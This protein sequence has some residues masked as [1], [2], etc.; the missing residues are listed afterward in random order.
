M[1]MDKKT[2]RLIPIYVSVFMILFFVF[3]YTIRESIYGSNTVAFI[4]IAISILIL[5]IN[6]LRNFNINKCNGI[7]LACSILF[8]LMMLYNN[9]YLRIGN[10]FVPLTYGMFILLP[11]LIA[12]NKKIIEVIKKVIHIFFIEH[13][14]FTL[15]ALIFKKAYVKYLLPFIA[16]GNIILANSQYKIGYNPGLTTHYTTNAIYLS[17]SLLFYVSRF[18][19]NRKLK[20]LAM[21][22]LSL[23]C[24]LLT[25]KRGHLVF[26]IAAIVIYIIAFHKKRTI[27]EYSKMI[28]IPI[29]A[30]ILIFAISIKVPQIL[31]VFKRFEASSIT[32]L[33]NGR[34]ELYNLA[35][36]NW[37]NHIVF[38]NGW[39]SAMYLYHKELYKPNAYNI[40]YTQT[41]NVYLQ[42]LCE[43]GI[44]GL[45]FVL[46]IFGTMLVLTFKAC[47]KNRN[48][49]ILTFSF[50]YQTFFILYCLT[51]NPLY[52]V[53]CY[54][55]Y[56]ISIG[57]ALHY[58]VSLK[59][60]NNKAKEKIGIV[61]FHNADNYGAMLQTYALYSYLK[62]TCNVEVIDY[63][64][65]Y[66]EKNYQL[67][68]K[69]T[70][71]I[72]LAI[73]KWCMDLC[74]LRRR[75]VRRTNFEQYRSKIEITEEVYS[76]TDI[77]KKRYNCIISGSDQVW[78]TNLTGGIDDIYFL[79][80]PKEKLKAKK[81]SY[82][83][84]CGEVSELGVN[85]EQAISLIKDFDC[86]SVREKNLEEYLKEEAGIN[87]ETVVDPTLLLSKEEWINMI[88]THPVEKGKYI[89]VYSVGKVNSEFY[90]IVNS[91][92]RIMNLKIIYFDV[93]KINNQYNCKKKNWYTAGPDEFLNL[94]YNAEFV[95]TT[96]FHGLAMSVLLNKKICIIY[97]KRSSRLSSLV[98]TLGLDDVVYRN[99]SDIEEI[100]STDIDW[101]KIELKLAKEREK[102]IIWLQENV[103][104]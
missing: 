64:N 31:N 88:D 98:E 66:I 61:T 50:I 18:I 28:F 94:L 12:N 38:G 57:I 56:Y 72:I 3:N 81:V 1:I 15:F 46:L 90:K 5:A 77:A 70:D 14:F 103:N 93:K 32:E 17:I 71:G 74:R 21:V 92:S 55:V 22:V 91:I 10:E 37:K 86:I 27:K 52:D 34:Q 42:L 2:V 20:D 73:A 82:A 99:G 11:I 6:T 4:S 35:I 102:S 30:L 78:N 63:R 9:C 25:A 19:K 101:D 69:K 53:Q 47:K 33:L 48:D 62:K 79:N 41:H 89:L 24:L 29:I 45:L 75:L 26:S 44:I 51:G 13:I 60:Q 23:L 95:I 59:T 49:Y 58:Y 84:S 104:K 67:F 7:I 76:I 43:N 16:N 8:T 54:V 39:G 85:K 65:K 87:T 96:S 80:I 97:N 40:D 100:I 36:T 83:A 68:R